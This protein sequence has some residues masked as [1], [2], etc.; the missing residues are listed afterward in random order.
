LCRSFE[1]W[2]VLRPISSSNPWIFSCTGSSCDL[3]SSE[4]TGLRIW[5]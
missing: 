1:F 2:A 4:M 3:I 5:W